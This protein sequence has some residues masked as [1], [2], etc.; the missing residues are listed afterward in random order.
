MCTKKAEVGSSSVG[1]KE[2]RA[3]GDEESD[4][5][6][7]AI[8]YSESDPTSESVR[9][10]SS[11]KS[12][13]VSLGVEAAEGTEALEVE[14]EPEP[15]W[16]LENWERIELGESD[17]LLTVLRTLTGTRCGFRRLRLPSPCVLDFLGAV[18]FGT[19]PCICTR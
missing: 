5:E 6:M 7:L 2:E 12:E 14:P 10:D 16:K 1:D 17:S 8:E 11:D 15:D 9:S 13:R 4:G 19:Y 18:F 3:D